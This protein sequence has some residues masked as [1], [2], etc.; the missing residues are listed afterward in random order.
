M[1][2]E[3]RFSPQVKIFLD[4]RYRD[5]DYLE[6]FEDRILK[7]SLDYQDY[8]AIPGIWFR[9][10]KGFTLVVTGEFR[11]KEYQERFPRARDGTPVF[12]FFPP[13]ASEKPFEPREYTYRG[14]NLQ[15]EWELTDRWEV[16]GEYK[17][18]DRKDEFLGYMDYQSQDV[19]LNFRGK[20]GKRFTLTFN[21]SYCS[22]SAKVAQAESLN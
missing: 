1:N 3:Y 19:D 8:R 15:W 10:G 17:F 21:T 2:L 11:L 22:T 16:E 13:G 14:I 20:F 7:D 9:P 4:L 12:P 6:D 18:T 5:K